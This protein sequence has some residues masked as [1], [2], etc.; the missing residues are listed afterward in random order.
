[1]STELTELFSGYFNPFGVM[2]RKAPKGD[3]ITS[4]RQSDDSIEGA[5]PNR[6]H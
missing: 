3:A 4:P 6:R 1:M 2:G 5:E